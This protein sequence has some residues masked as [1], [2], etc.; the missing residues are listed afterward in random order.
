MDTIMKVAEGGAFKKLSENIYTAF[1]YVALAAEALIEPIVNALTNAM[2]SIAGF[3][4]QVAA[5][6]ANPLDTWRLIVNNIAITFLSIWETLTGIANKLSLGL[7]AKADMGD[8]KQGLAEENE[9]AKA[10]IAAS[11]EA[12]DKQVSD[13]KEKFTATVTPSASNAGALGM[14]APAATSMKASSSAFNSLLSG[15]FAQKPDKQLAVM[16]QIAVNTT[17]KDTGAAPVTNKATLATP[18]TGGGI[19]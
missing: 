19:L 3:A 16:Q 6:L 12:Y 4:A 1:S 15:V 5:Y 2:A 8:A 13:M 9:A 18:K 7:I 17:P 10:R 14:N 11:K